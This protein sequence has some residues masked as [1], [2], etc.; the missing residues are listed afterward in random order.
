M[1][2]ERY[3][4][5]NKLFQLKSTDGDIVDGETSEMVSTDS[6]SMDAR[7]QRHLV[8]QQFNFCL[9]SC[10]DTTY[11]NSSNIQCQICIYLTTLLRH[12]DEADPAL[13][14]AEEQMSGP[15]DLAAEEASALE[16]LADAGLVE[17]HAQGSH[18]Y[19]RMADTKAAV[20][21]TD[22][23]AE[24]GKAA[25]SLLSRMTAEMRAAMP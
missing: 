15:F 2:I 16:N 7:M 10:L 5:F 20:V 24:T 6:S 9:P 14:D 1:K 21:E 23:G 8:L 3:G 4:C 17:R 18:A 13:V 22:Q 19:Y 12:D 11:I 25:D